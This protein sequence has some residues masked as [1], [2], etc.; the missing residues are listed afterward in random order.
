MGKVALEGMKFYAYHGF[1]EEERI[2][3]NYYV[4]D[5][6]LEIN[7]KSYKKAVARDN[8]YDTVNYETVYLIVQAEMRKKSKL[9]ETIA[10]RIVYHV[11]KQFDQ[12]REVQVRIR[13][14]NP[15]L[16]G[17]VGQALVETNESFVKNCDRCGEAMLCYG[18][19]TCWC[20]DPVIY[21]KT[22]ETIAAHYKD[23][24]CKKCI[25]YYAN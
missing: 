3:G 10:D 24:L 17:P 22:Q 1:Y 25:A 16:G 8:L 21:Q 19:D 5:V 15:P 12:V 6:Y 14:E 7:T 20:M 23:C 2:V 4:I 18:D 11:K 13:K 9:L